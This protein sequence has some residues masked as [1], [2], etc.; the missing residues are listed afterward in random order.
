MTMSQ[1]PLA[2][3]PKGHVL[4]RAGV[5]NGEAVI[6]YSAAVGGMSLRVEKGGA[7]RGRFNAAAHWSSFPLTARDAAIDA[8]GYCKACHQNFD[9]DMIKLGDILKAHGAPIICYPV[10]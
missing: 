8:G 3:C 2:K 6:E 5:L 1:N 7:P 9:L 4:A 10:S